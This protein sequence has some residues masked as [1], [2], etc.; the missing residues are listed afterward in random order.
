MAK[1][2]TPYTIDDIKA[3][4]KLHE[5]NAA[6]FEAVA[7]AAGVK[8]GSVAI[9]YYRAMKAENA[10][11]NTPTTAKVAKSRPMQVK[12]WEAKAKR[13]PRK[14]RKVRK[15]RTRGTGLQESGTL[16]GR[17]GAA[18]LTTL[19]TL[20]ATVYNVPESLLTALAE[21]SAAVARK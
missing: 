5:T 7:K 15:A 17:Q 2:T 14:V 10:P 11:E 13:A 18:N 3:A 1:S 16:A 12:A 19:H 9:R 6:A 20:I 21:A 4:I 8:P